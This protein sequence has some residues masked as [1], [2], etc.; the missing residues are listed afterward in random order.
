[1]KMNGSNILERSEQEILWANITFTR[2]SVDFF[3]V[4]IAYRYNIYVSQ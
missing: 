2:Y 4:H 3:R 1:M